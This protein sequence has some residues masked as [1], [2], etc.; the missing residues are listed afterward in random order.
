MDRGV[1]KVLMIEDNPGDARLIQEMLREVNRGKIKFEQKPKLSEG[2]ERLEQ[3]DIDVVLLD[4]GLPDSK[5]IETLIE[6]RKYETRTPIVVLTGL[7]DEE[8]GLDAL[9]LGAQDYL[10]KMQV[11][12]QLLFR[13]IQ[14]AI[15]RKKIEEKLRES[16]DRFRA[17][18][19]RAA[20]GIGHFSKSGRWTKINTK[21][22]S[23]LG[24]PE[25]K[26]LSGVENFFSILD[27][28]I[29]NKKMLEKLWD[30]E[31]PD[32]KYEKQFNR[33][34]EDIWLQIALSVVQRSYDEVPYGVAIIED[35]TQ[36]R[37]AELAVAES[38]KK[39]FTIFRE[40]QSPVVITDLK[41]GVIADINQAFE[42]ALGYT[43]EE[44]LGK[45]TSEIDLFS[46][47]DEKVFNKYLIEQRE[48][49]NAE[50]KINKQNGEDGFFIVSSSIVEIE[51]NEFVLT[52]M[53][54]ITE[55]VIAE[56]KIKTFNQQLQK[57]KA[58]LEKKSNE[59]SSLTES[60]KDL[61][62]SKDKFFSIIAHDLRSPFSALLGISDFMNQHIDEL[63]HDEVKDF[64]S[65]LNR[66]LNGIFKLVENLLQ[67]SRMQSGRI[68][69]EPVKFNLSSLTDEIFELY[70][71]SFKSKNIS[72]VKNYDD[73]LS[74]FAD[75][76]MI[77]TVLRNLISNAIKFTHSNGKIII[78]A[79]EKDD[80]IE[81]CVAD[82]G[83]G[84]GNEDKKKLFKIDETITTEGT[85]NEKGTGLG[86][87]LCKEF[88]EKNGG[89]IWVKSALG[90]GSQFIF[91]LPVCNE[92]KTELANYH[93]KSK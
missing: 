40:T 34:G 82:N 52:T 63:T 1:I 21:L 42:E 33:N 4:L 25:D 5:G 62:A 78:T 12:S 89:K 58:E 67:W 48:I 72:V 28:D 41:T 27:E 92:K 49:K 84:I 51:R 36:R 3:E 38:E 61:N 66:S 53:H 79:E 19:D 69:F 37:R 30:N 47:N 90:K 44:V 81:V 64:S 50:I 91:T 20:I 74:V 35:I 22:S 31:I 32:I 65:H 71:Q 13:T 45:E 75:R 29:L 88:V 93:R 59:L 23:I 8:L 10:S 24:I 43:R 26:L 54:E 55:R 73:E 70:K 68:D 76:N 85:E 56:E 14:Y 15:E 2:I 46:A 77:N 16:E 80:F 11:D 83:I 87:V 86:L 57:N 39:F 6:L 18:F 9:K 17:T 7:E 60:L